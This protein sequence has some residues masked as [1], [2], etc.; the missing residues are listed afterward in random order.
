MIEL[1]DKIIL[2][3]LPIIT[4][5]IGYFLGYTHNQRIN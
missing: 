4:L 2:I 1:N 5:V 3:A